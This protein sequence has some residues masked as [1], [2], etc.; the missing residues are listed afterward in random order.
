MRNLHR[1]LP[2][3]AR[4]ANYLAYKIESKNE[5]LSVPSLRT[6]NALVALINPGQMDRQDL[7]GR[8]EELYNQERFSTW[9][10]RV[11]ICIGALQYFVTCCLLVTA[12]LFVRCQYYPDSFQDVFCTRVTF[13]VPWRPRRGSSS[14]LFARI[15]EIATERFA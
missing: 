8:R 1:R 7:R 14:C 15:W 2:G 4:K 12:P 13:Q 6:E 9:Q 11:V 5:I 3:R 10:C